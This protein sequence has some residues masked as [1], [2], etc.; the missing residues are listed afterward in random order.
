M[1]VNKH[2][3]KTHLTRVNA[4]MYSCAISFLTLY[5]LNVDNILLSIYLDY[6][7]NLLSFIMAPNNLEIKVSLLFF[8][9][10]HFNS[11]KCKNNL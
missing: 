4:H 1:C 2:L 7:A 10:L 5:T 3:I 8:K 9:L 11:M 6:F